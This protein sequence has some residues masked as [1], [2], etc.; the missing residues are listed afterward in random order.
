MIRRG[1]RRSR[2]NILWRFEHLPTKIG[3]V[4]RRELC[5]DF[6]LVRSRIEKRLL[7]KKRRLHSRLA[8]VLAALDALLEHRQIAGAEQHA[9]MNARQRN[10]RPEQCRIEAGE[11]VLILRHFRINGFR[12]IEQR[13][14]LRRRKVFPVPLPRQRRKRFP[15]RIPGP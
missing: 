2:R 4:A 13:D 8:A 10:L 3:A 1:R 15:Q 14:L 12:P 9:R 11:V 5:E 7:E 6:A